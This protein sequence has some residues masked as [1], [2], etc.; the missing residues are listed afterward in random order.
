MKTRPKTWIDDLKVY[1]PGLPIEEVARKLGFDSADEIIKLASN[2]NALGPSPEAIEAMRE[3]AAEMHLYPDGSCHYLRHA[4]AERRGLDPGEILM[5]NGSNELIEL[6]GH[7]YLEEGANIVMSDQA[8]VVYRLVAGLF[9]AETIATPMVNFTHDLEAMA[10]AINE[11]TRIVFIANP[12]NPTGTMVG[13]EALD[14]FMERVPTEVLVVLDQAY[15]ELLPDEKRTNVLQYIREG[16]NVC[17]LRTFSKAYGLAGLRIGYAM[18]PGPIIDLLGRTR[19]PFNANAMAQAA[20]IAALDDIEHLDR[21][22]KMVRDGLHYLTGEFERLGFGVVPS[23]V[24]FMLVKVG[25]G[26]ACFEALQKKGVVVR[27]MDGYGLPDHVRVT[28]GTREENE[29]LIK[30]LEA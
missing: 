24:N 22:R 15:V 3:S 7:V 25:E 11:R 27:P 5:G 9:N 12:N 21:T 8:F 26:R 1:E 6:L 14:R 19:Q 30:A 18:A 23:E 29:K 10:E 13:R 4:L 20:A 16:R 28:V 2:E 17:V